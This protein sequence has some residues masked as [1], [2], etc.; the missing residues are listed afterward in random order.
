MKKK[1]AFVDHSFHKKTY[2][3]DFL[4]NIFL[5]KYQLD[6]YWDESWTGGPRVRKSILAKYS[7]L[8]YFQLLNPYLD[9]R[10]LKTSVIW[11]P[12]FDSETVN[13]LRLDR[14]VYYKLL[15]QL[16]L[17]VVCFSKKLF[18][19]LKLLG[20]RCQYFQYFMNP[21]DFPA[22]DDYK[23]KRVFFWDRGAINFDDVKKIIGQQKIDQLVLMVNPDPGMN[24]KLPTKNDIKKY[25]IKIINGH[26]SQQKYRQLLQKSNIFI[27]PRRKEGIG[28][29][30]LEAMT[31]GQ[32]IIAFNESTMNEYIESGKN[33]ILVNDY[34]SEVDLSDFSKLGKNSRKFC[35]DGYREW[36]SKRQNIVKFPKIRDHS[37]IDKIYMRLLF[38]IWVLLDIIYRPMVKM[39]T[40][41]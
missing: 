9:L 16:N 12:M 15:S 21:E 3:G 11:A 27:A 14:T 1:I 20:F 23:T 41:N 25:N 37:M 29:S 7:N 34:D 8:V 28:M 4:R 6:N 40:K 17:F 10:D 38:Y 19:R 13:R 5:H 30:F 18:L 39:M 33:G 35:L 26:A 36:S 31:F 2:S 22:V 32:C 24:N